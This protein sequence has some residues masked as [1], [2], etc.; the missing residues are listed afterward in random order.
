MLSCVCSLIYYRWRQNVIKTSVTHSPATR[1][2][3]LWFYDILTSFVIYYWRKFQNVIHASLIG[4]G[5]KPI[6]ARVTFTTLSK[7]QIFFCSF[8]LKKSYTAGFYYMKSNSK[9]LFSSVQAPSLMKEN[10]LANLLRTVVPSLC[11]CHYQCA[12]AIL[13][14]LWALTLATTCH[15]AHFWGNFIVC[16]KY[17]SV[18]G[19]LRN[20]KFNIFRIFLESFSL[21]HTDCLRHLHKCT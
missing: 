13:N 2:A 21:F 17:N 7:K 4:Y 11:A 9:K 19:F 6:T 5:Q 1:V 16:S 12:C 15:N 10:H 18:F 3:L 8:Q 20:K 14:C